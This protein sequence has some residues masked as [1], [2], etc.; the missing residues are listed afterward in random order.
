MRKTV[1]VN[2]SDLHVVTRPVNHIRDKS[3][4]HV[5][6][7]GRPGDPNRA[8]RNRRHLVLGLD[9]GGIAVGR[10]GPTDFDLALRDAVR[11]DRRSGPMIPTMRGTLK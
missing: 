5:R 7:H 2:T 8:L 11:A 1:H 9:K 4:R 3:R 10:D 6:L